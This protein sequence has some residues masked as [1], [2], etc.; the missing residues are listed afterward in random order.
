MV[1]LF[2]G[3]TFC[4]LIWL[5]V[6][7]D[8]QRRQLI[9][10]GRK[11]RLLLMLIEWATFFSSLFVQGLLGS[12]QFA[13]DFWL[14]T[15]ILGFFGYFLKRLFLGSVES[16]WGICC[17][18]LIGKIFFSVFYQLFCLGVVYWKVIRW[19]WQFF[20]EFLR[21]FSIKLMNS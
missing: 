2:F 5:W 11:I 18:L 3:K 13:I 21:S 16:F 1:L 14:E 15:I 19:V 17:E 12:R 7:K 4:F 20:I 9:R 8:G 10:S 6:G